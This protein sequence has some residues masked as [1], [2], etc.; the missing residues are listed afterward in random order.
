MVKDEEWQEVKR[1]IG[2]GRVVL[3]SKSPRRKEIMEKELGFRRVSVFPSGFP[4]DLHKKSMSPFEYVL[5]TAEAKALDVYRSEATAD[6]P[7]SALIAADTIVLL[8]NEILEKPTDVEHHVTMLKKLRDAKSHKVYTAVVCIVPFDEPVDPGYAMESAIEETEVLF[9]KQLTDEQIIEYVATGEGSDAAG[10]YKIQE[11]GGKVLIDKIEG[12]YHNVV[13]LPV[14]LTKRVLVK[15]ATLANNST[16]SS[17]S[18]AESE[19][20]DEDLY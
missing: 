1:T 8:D 9:K 12:D 5:Q 11:T 19:S 7:P 17:Q 15:C 16:H 10:G 13:G 18:S 6:E 4:E 20:E 2:D 3:A 14:D